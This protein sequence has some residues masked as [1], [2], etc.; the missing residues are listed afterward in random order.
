MLKVVIAI[1][2]FMS[3]LSI[4][5]MDMKVL[6]EEIKVIRKMEDAKKEMW[7]QFESLVLKSEEETEKFELKELDQVKL[8]HKPDDTIKKQCKLISTQISALSRK[9]IKKEIKA[10]ESMK[11]KFAIFESKDNMKKN[12]NF[13]EQKKTF[14]D[15]SMNAYKYNPTARGTTWTKKLCC[16]CS[17]IQNKMGVTATVTDSNDKRTIINGNIYIPLSSGRC[18]SEFFNDTITFTEFF[19]NIDSLEEALEFLISLRMD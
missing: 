13:F 1:C 15:S 5:S 9:I 8:I 19:A 18:D 3:R 11:K 17:F 2:L 14:F 6:E 12:E 10:T 7:N 16:F 4:G